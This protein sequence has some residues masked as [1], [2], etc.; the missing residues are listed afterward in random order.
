MKYA[1]RGFSVVVPG[2]DKKFLDK[3]RIEERYPG[4]P[5]DY[6]VHV[7]KD[8]CHGLTKLLVNN[9]RIH[10]I[11]GIVEANVYHKKMADIL[12]SEGTKIKKQK[13]ERGDKDYGFLPPWGFFTKKIIED[14]QARNIREFTLKDGSKA[15]FIPVSEF[16]NA[17][18]KKYINNDGLDSNTFSWIVDNPGRYSIGIFE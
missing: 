6:F 10:T 13:T 3:H 18:G 11:S 16:E 15:Y 9:M 17:R 7:S 1:K 2:Y 4:S 8:E 14:Y 5:S 12:D